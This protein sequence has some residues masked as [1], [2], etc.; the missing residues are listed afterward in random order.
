MSKAKLNK[1][2]KSGAAPPA[3]PGPTP[4]PPGPTPPPGHKDKNQKK[5]F[6]KDTR[7]KKPGRPTPVPAPLAPPEDPRHYS[8]NWKA[9]LQTMKTNPEPKTRDQNKNHVTKK[10]SSKETTAPASCLTSSQ[11]AGGKPAKHQTL[12]SKETVAPAE[13][14]RSKSTKKKKV[15]GERDRQQPAKR[16]DPGERDRQQPAKRKDPGEKD[17]QQPAKRKDPGERDRQQP[18]KRKDPGERDRQ[19][20]AKRKKKEE[21]APQP[22]PPTE[23]DLWFDDVDPDDIEATLG[24]EA[25]DVVRSRT[26]AHKVPE[27]SLVKNNAFTGLTRAVAMDCEMVGVGPGGEDS[28]LARV[29]I[30]NHFGKLIYDRFVRPSE[31]VTDYRTAVSGVRPEDVRDGEEMKTVQKEVSDILEGR[32]LVGHAIHNDLKVLF[33]DHPKK[34]IRDTQK[35]KPFRQTAQSSRP[36]LKVLC[37]EML[38]VKVHQGEHC[39]V[40]DAQ[41]TMKLYTMVKKHWEAEIKASRAPGGVA[42]KPRPSKYKSR[43]SKDKR[44]H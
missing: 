9:L 41:A 30:V 12:S 14:Q 8:V 29:S 5:K 36:S 26:E 34:R 38:N 10:H 42:E 28:V 32:I 11:T 21:V 31:E 22:R 4:P 16:K 37:R 7:R 19:Q 40:Q 24:K 27:E 20:P 44:P 6:F 1:T 23:A 25:A 18:A 43:P 15:P 33:M 39:S 35:Y 2:K 3:P 13:E 17:R